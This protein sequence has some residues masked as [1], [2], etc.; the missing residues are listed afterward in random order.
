MTVLIIFILIF[1]ILFFLWLIVGYI[2]FKKAIVRGHELDIRD[3]KALLGTAWD[4]YYD[5]ILLGISWI[6]K[7]PKENVEVTSFDGLRLRGRLIKNPKA[8][9]IV[10]MFHGYRT[11]PEVD[12]SVDSYIYY[13]GG[14][15]LLMVDERASGE[16]EGKYIGFGVLESYDVKT[17]CE[18][19]C[20]RFGEDFPIILCGL[21]MGG[22]AVLM[23]IER[24]LPKN[25]CRII[26]DS[27]FT[28]PAAVIKNTIKKSFKIG[29]GPGVA[30][31]DFF[32]R[33]FAK[34]SIF[35][36]NLVK[37]MEKNTIPLFL[38]HGKRDEVVPFE[39][40]MEVYEACNAPK[41]LLISEEADHGTTYL[42]E[43][44]K[45]KEILMEIVNTTKGLPQEKVF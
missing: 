3:R 34:Y 1:A 17:W 27:A 11:H 39:M 15:H 37:S 7:K 32:A 14:N 5:E 23:S 26:A 33:I 12:F 25:V 19:A 38:I 22:S 35:S 44:E 13:G 28:S 42:F 21:S 41:I 30:G 43:T 6:E 9:G 18:Y 16:S 31:I 10:I 4:R 29:A 24:E 40:T 8:T 36:G 45:Y 20:E 2:G